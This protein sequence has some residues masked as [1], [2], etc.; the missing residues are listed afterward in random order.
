L[1]PFTDTFVRIFDVALVAPWLAFMNPRAAVLAATA[2]AVALAAAGALWFRLHQPA[3]VAPKAATRLVQLDDFPRRFVV[4][5][6]NLGRD[7]APAQAWPV[8][9]A[10]GRFT[11]RKDGGRLLI[12][13]DNGLRYAPF[14]QMTEAIDPREA[15]AAYLRIYPQL[16]NAYEE[17]GFPRRHF[18]T[19]LVEVMDLLLATPV[20]DGPI[21]VVLPPVRGPIQPPRPWMLYEY[22]DPALRQLTA[23]QQWL[24]RLGP[25]NQRRLQS[26][27]AELRALLAR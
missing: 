24:L 18:N 11:V 10:P 1:N 25:V 27:L 23:G 22:A 17:S 5:V 12:D 7:A 4:T 15:V 3:P 14:V 13:A 16:Q 6:D 2:A 19:R 9:P 20:P 21:E 8:N 26:R